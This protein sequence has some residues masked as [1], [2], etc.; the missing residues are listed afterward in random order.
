V[1]NPNDLISLKLRGDRI[2]D[3]SAWLQYKVPGLNVTTLE[4]TK[5]DSVA[6]TSAVFAFKITKVGTMS[7][8]SVDG[9]EVGVLLGWAVG[10]RVGEPD[11]CAVGIME[12]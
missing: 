5:I 12:G 2:K 8:G 4:L 1:L 9:E 6:V 3:D 11:G 10:R 7:F